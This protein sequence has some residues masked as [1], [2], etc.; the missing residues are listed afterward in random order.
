MKRLAAITILLVTPAIAQDA[1]VESVTAYGKS[2]VGLW[3]VSRP[4]YVA[5]TGFFSTIQWGPLHDTFCRIAPRNDDLEMHCPL[6]WQT[7]AVT[8]DGDHVHFA[9]GTLMARGILDGEMVSAGHFRGHFQIKVSGFTFES[10]DFA[11][12]ARVTPDP[13][14]PGKAGKAMLL[15]QILDDGWTSVP[16][17]ADAMKNT[18]SRDPPKLG[19]VQAVTYLGQETKWGTPPPP[20][21]KT[22]GPN[23]IPDQPDFFSVYLVGFA[24]GERLCSLHQREDGVLDA[25]HCV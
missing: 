6:G 1:P 12:A 20:P 25:F 23:R 3:R 2:L 7:A 15:R 5:V 10:S 11:E 8:A 24:E 18:E 9:W 16:H 13:A 21:G 19:A 14:A 4:N 17:D 22:P